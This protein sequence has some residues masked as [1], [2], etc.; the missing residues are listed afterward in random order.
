MHATCGGIGA[1]SRQLMHGMMPGPWLI[2]KDET[3]SMRLQRS[4]RACTKKEENTIFFLEWCYGSEQRLHRKGL[5]RPWLHCNDE[6]AEVTELKA[7]DEF[8]E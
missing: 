1:G 6:V 8:I 4:N 3:E 5:R 7:R 2:Q